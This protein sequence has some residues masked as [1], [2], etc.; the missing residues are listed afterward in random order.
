[1]TAQCAREGGVRSFELVLGNES[2]KVRA[3][4]LWTSKTGDPNGRIVDVDD[5]AVPIE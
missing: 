1:M 2:G 3:D 4:D 5:L